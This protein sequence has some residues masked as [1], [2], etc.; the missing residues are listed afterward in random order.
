DL[1]TFQ[2]PP[3]TSGGEVFVLHLPSVVHDVVGAVADEKGQRPGPHPSALSGV[4]RTHGVDVVRPVGA[5][6]VRRER[7]PLGYPQPQALRELFALS[8]DGVTENL[9]AITP[10]PAGS[11]AHL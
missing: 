11:L 7:R 1:E 4:V 8:A 10:S 5:Q 9:I 2:L 6:P 3:Q